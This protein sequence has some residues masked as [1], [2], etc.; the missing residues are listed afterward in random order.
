MRADLLIRDLSSPLLDRLD[1]AGPRY[2]SYPTVPVWTPAF[3]EA[4]WSDAIAHAGRD[5]HGEPTVPLAMYAHFPYCAQKCL[6]CGCNALVTRNPARQDAYLDALA[7]ELDLV[8]DALGA[9]R[10]L[11]QLHWGGGTPNHQREDQLRRSIDLFRQ[12]FDFT[13]DAELS[14]E[15]DPRCVAPGQLE[16][17]ASLGFNR[18]SFGV[19]D[20]DPAVQEA[21]GRRQPESMVRQV[22]DDARAAGFAEVNLDVMYGLPRQTTETLARTLDAVIAMAPDRVA[23]FG[24]AHLPQARRHQGAIDEREL[25]GSR[26]RLELFAQAVTAFTEDGYVWVGLDHFAAPHDPLAKAA[27]RQQVHRNFMGYM[28]GDTGDLVGV[29]VSAIGD[30]AGCYA[31]NEAR[32][33]EYMTRVAAE[34][35]PIVRGHRLSEDDRTRR[36]AIMQLMCNGSLPYSTFTGDLAPALD[37]LSAWEMDDLVEFAPDELRVTTLGRF[38]VRTLAFALDAYLPAQQVQ[39]SKAV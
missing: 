38:F 12:R 7:Q 32:L 33:P 29:G 17:L 34:A 18:I 26:T 11:R 21:I 30:A 3:G 6:Y 4:S 16:L 35:L 2:T 10:T 37:T 28:P 23:C 36:A 9:P 13:P 20:L 1:R 22:V 24:Y 14:I 31:Q 15:A 25:P 19:Q 5:A 27:R 8:T 39:Y